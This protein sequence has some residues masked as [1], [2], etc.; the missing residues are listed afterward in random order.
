MSS[1]SLPQSYRNSV[2]AANNAR[3]AA[4]GIKAGLAFQREFSQLT[5][6]QK[7]AAVRSQAVTTSPWAMVG[8]L[9]AQLGIGH[10]GGIMAM[11]D[12]DAARA[13]TARDPARAASTLKKA[14][15]DD[16]GLTEAERNAFNKLKTPLSARQVTVNHG[17]NMEAAYRGDG[18]GVTAADQR[19]IQAG[20]A[21]DQAVRNAV[22][23]GHISRSEMMDINARRG[24]AM[25]QVVQAAIADTKA[26]VRGK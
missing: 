14:F 5:V 13:N 11:R 24:E 17:G 16:N 10:L 1:V 2:N 9:P 7:E 15:G 20:R 8:S 23:D 19:A 4:D 21:I 6:A 12:Q 26:G 22:A 25:R 3:G 18:K